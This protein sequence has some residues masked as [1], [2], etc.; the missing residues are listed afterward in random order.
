M[1]S[2]LRQTRTHL[3]A[4]FEQQGLHPRHD[5][6][7][8][9]LI[10]LNL[11]ESIVTEADLGPDDVVLEIGSGTGGLTTFLAAEAGSVV[12]VEFDPKMFRFAHEATSHL[13]DVT[14]LNCDALKNKNQLNPLVVEAITAQLSAAP[15]RRLKLVANLPY[16]VGT[17]ILA[18]LL[19]SDF[20]LTRMVVT[21]QFELAQRL[22]A[23]PRTPEYSA[24]SVYFQA[25]CQVTLVHKL[26]PNVFWPRPKVDSAIV[27]IEPNPDARARI[28][29]RAAFQSFL[30]DIFT[31]RRK[32]LGGVLAQL[33]RKS[34][35]KSEINELFEEL[36]L[37]VDARAEALE[38]S[39]LVELSNRLHR[40]T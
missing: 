28:H 13:P 4:L 16:H 9:F 29:D 38:V 2:P 37:P 12:S 34:M 14:L 17:P 5:L 3:M 20:P 11:L 35:S 7:Q 10:D 36:N 39:Q 31:Q 19:A 26:G 32:M 6:G 1:H 40:A 22:N 27:R 25:Q 23:K 30:R 24:L 33:Y 21:I 15:D 18:N 8:N